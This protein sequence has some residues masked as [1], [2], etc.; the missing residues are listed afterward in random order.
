[1]NAVLL[2]T[3]FLI[4][5]SDPNRP[6]HDVAVMYYKE[7]I[8]LRVRMMLSTIVVSEFQVRQSIMDLQL[9]NFIV[10]PFNID[11]AMTCGLLAKNFPRDEG[12]ERAR[13]KD[14]MKLLAQCKCDEI[15]YMFTEDAST[16][17]KYAA[18][19][20]TTLRVVL[21]KC[22]FDAAH[23]NGGQA[24]LGLSPDASPGS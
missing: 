22:G 16:L 20:S 15:N 18:R 12:D 7:C 5:L 10:L 6:Q 2:D 14:D 24:P 17:T 8:R 9:R 11:H 23:F 4:S 13:V 3:S 21:L 1:M 19:V